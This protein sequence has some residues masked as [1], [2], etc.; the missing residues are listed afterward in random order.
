MS[1]QDEPGEE[2]RAAEVTRLDEIIALSDISPRLWRLYAYFWLG[3]LFFPILYLTQTPLTA[4]PLLVALVG[5]AIFTA[6]YFW[7]M[8]PYPLSDRG[9]TRS[10]MRSSPLLLVGITL[11]VLFLSLAYG[12]TFTWL[13]VGVSAITG[14]VLPA[15]QAFWVVMGLTL[16]TLGIGVVASGGI[17]ATDWLQV[18]PL[19]LLVRGVGLDMAGLS[20][21]AVALWD[22]NAA[23]QELARQAVVAER[24]RMARDLH[25]LL[26]H[27][28]SL[29]TL[30]SELARRLVEKKFKASCPGVD[31]D[32]AR[33]TP[34]M[35]GGARSHAGVSKQD[36]CQ[37]T[38]WRP[39]DP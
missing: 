27:T 21:L 17:A 8:W 11:L 20:R 37:R 32:R 18:V 3:C 6:A 29:I 23:R 25:D 39:A 30:K 13:F 5:L 33:G 24:L 1:D 2:K 19:T 16:L 14:I 26:G 38:R 7:I 9:R 34:V 28:L 10:G 22:L 31:R 12:S 15:R 36:A 35:A 4:L